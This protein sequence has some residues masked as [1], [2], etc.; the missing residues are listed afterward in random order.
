MRK[1]SL[2][3]IVPVHNVEPYIER[4]LES[5]REINSIDVTFYLVEN[6]SSDSSYEICEKAAENDSRFVLLKLSEAGVS[7][8]RNQA[9]EMCDSEYVTFMD[10]D[11]YI[12]SEAFEKAFSC[13]VSQEPDLYFSPYFTEEDG[14]KSLV[15]MNL[16]K[17]EFR[18]DEIF[19]GIVQN[20]LAPG[21]KFFGCVWRVF[22]KRSLIGDLRFNKEM[23]YQEDVAF[24]I[25][26]SLRAKFAIANDDVAYYNYRTNQGSANANPKVNNSARRLDLI[27]EL[28]D[29]EKNS[30]QDFGFAIAQ[31][32]VSYY[33]KRCS[34]IVRCSGVGNRIRAVLEVHRQLESS[35]IVLCDSRVLGKFFS[36][37]IR[38]RAKGFH[39]LALTLMIGRYLFC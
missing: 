14:K 28:K 17:S 38:M 32:T 8:A 30:E 9:L 19:S 15:S 31:R 20:R 34:E 3:V 23:C 35:H 18:D 37:Y 5:L 26:C 36:I 1:K 12:D 13:C 24:L 4:C 25:R 29:I 7:N 22:F 2:S 6:G 33:A 11:D 27:R 16:K 39:R 10:A 21:I